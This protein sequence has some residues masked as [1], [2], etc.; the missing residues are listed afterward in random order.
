MAIY[1]NTYIYTK[2]I[3]IYT[4]TVLRDIRCLAAEAA[5]LSCLPLF[6]AERLQSQLLKHGD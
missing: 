4:H 1:T 5:A 2:Y 6:T 3:Y